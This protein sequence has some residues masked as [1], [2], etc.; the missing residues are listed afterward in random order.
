[1][2]FECD[3][4]ENLNF[5]VSANSHV[6]KIPILYLNDEIKITSMTVKI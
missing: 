5:V 6:L 1:M 4:D 3:A 2:Y